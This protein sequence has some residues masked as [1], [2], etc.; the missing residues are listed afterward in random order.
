[1]CAKRDLCRTSVNDD[2]SYKLPRVPIYGS[3]YKMSTE[4]RE[5]GHSRIVNELLDSG[6]HEFEIR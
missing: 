3:I 4:E 1:M 6:R 5:S 2:R